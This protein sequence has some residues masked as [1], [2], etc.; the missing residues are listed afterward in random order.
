[1]MQLSQNAFGTYLINTAVVV[2]SCDSGVGIRLGRVSLIE[3]QG[4]WQRT[5]QNE[6]VTQMIVGRILT[7]PRAQ[8]Q[9]WE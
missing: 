3:L 1:M 4:I 8:S 6:V 7:S 2:F 5:L 9:E